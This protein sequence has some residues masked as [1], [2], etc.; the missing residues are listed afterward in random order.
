MTLRLIPAIHRATHQIGL[1]LESLRAQVSQGEAHTLAHLA[2]HGEASIGQLHRALAHRRST[3]TGILDR[4]V[5]RG[6]VTRELSRTDRRSF[7]VSLTE[8]G[9][10]VASTVL[11][12]LRELEEHALA[13][14]GADQ[15][16]PLLVAL[17]RLAPV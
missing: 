1:H 12:V 11:R 17:E 4:L 16:A 14:I 2:E 15:V 6:L 7:T 10:R 5:A 3:L 13:G 8:D 9:A